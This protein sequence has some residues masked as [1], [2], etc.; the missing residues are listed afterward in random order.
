MVA[1][2]RRQKCPI[3][4][5]KLIYFIVYSSRKSTH[6]KFRQC[7]MQISMKYGTVAGSDKKRNLLM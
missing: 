1:F 2:N 6:A 5:S 4:S 3:V 7:I